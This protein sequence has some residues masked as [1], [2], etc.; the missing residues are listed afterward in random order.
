MA[1][2][3]K[4]FIFASTLTGSLVIDRK[5]AKQSGHE[6]PELSEKHVAA[7]LAPQDLPAGQ[8]AG[9]HHLQQEPVFLN[10]YGAQESIPRNEFRQPM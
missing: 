7:V 5:L 8:L 10:V 2:K 9:F 3:L 6:L 1:K 4:Q